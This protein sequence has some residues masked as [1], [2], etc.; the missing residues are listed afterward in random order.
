VDDL[1]SV[2]KVVH[3]LHHHAKP[4]EKSSLAILQQLDTVT[5]RLKNGSRKTGHTR[6]ISHHQ[7]HMQEQKQLAN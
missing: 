2:L 3:L 5:I 6:T 7:H 4:S 1:E